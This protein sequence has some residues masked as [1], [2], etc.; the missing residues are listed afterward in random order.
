[1]RNTVLS[2]FSH[3]W[4]I[5]PHKQVVFERVNCILCLILST[6]VLFFTLSRKIFGAVFHMLRTGKSLELIVGS[7]KLLVDLDKVFGCHMKHGF[8]SLYS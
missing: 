3:I 2:H 4:F 7:Y 1:M 6:K 5:L 8:L